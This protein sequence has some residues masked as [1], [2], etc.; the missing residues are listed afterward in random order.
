MLFNYWNNIQTT[1]T[2]QHQKTTQCLFR[3]PK[4]TFLQRRH[5]DDQS[6]RKMVLNIANLFYGHAPQHVGS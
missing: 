4:Y 3:R 6:A 1:H 5:T 2:T